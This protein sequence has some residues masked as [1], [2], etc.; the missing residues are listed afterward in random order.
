MSFD[1]SQFLKGLEGEGRRRAIAAGV[2]GVDQFANHVIGKAQKL[3]PIEFG[4][5]KASGV[6]EKAEAKGNDIFAVVGFNTNYAA[7]VHER[8]DL[9][10]DQGQAKYLEDAMRTE[11]PK[12]V[13][14]VEKE[15]RK[16]L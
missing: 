2:K 7:A 11:G 4:T 16:A 13:P 15:M 6:A 5:L 8:L 10:H 3:A 9:N 12:L 1:T 14:F